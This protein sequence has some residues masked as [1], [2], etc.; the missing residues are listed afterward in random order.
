MNKLELIPEESI[1][2]DLGGEFEALLER[3]SDI[4]SFSAGDIIKGK[5]TR[6]DKDGALIDVGFKS[7]GFLPTKEVANREEEKTV[8]DVLEF[9][10]EYDFYVI[11]EESDK[12]PLLLSYKR[13]AQARGWVKLEEIKANDDIVEGEVFAVV[14][15]GVVVEIHG[16]RGFVPASQLRST[17]EGEIEKGVVIKLKI[18]ELNKNS[19]KLICSRKVVIEEEK[20]NLREKA[21]VELEVGQV[22]S[23][24]VVRVAEFGA[25][26]DIGGID[27]LLPVSEISWQRINHPKEKLS[28]GDQISVKVLKIDESGKISLSLKRLEQDPW[29]EIEDKF[30]EGQIVKGSVVKITAFGAFIEI[31]PGVEGLL[32]SNEISDDEDATPDSFLEVGQ[33][34]EIIIK[35]LSPYERRILLSMRDIEQVQL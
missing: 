34:I 28:V 30:V 2:E 22:I 13:V 16:V 14:K 3:N 17:T 10:K 29:T 11:R 6:I 1:F 27:G 24:T 4:G 8:E 12:G 15:G 33:E 7:E 23:G 25:F 26:V 5:L 9:D 32:P 35:K 19:R 21:L 20:A 18:I 31:Y